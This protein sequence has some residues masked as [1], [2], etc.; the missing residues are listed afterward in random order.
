MNVLKRMRE[1]RLALLRFVCVAVIA[2][3]LAITGCAGIPVSDSKAQAPKNIVIIFADG[4]AATQWDFGRYSSKV[5]RQ[6][7]FVTADLF[8]DKAL[9]LLITSP[10]GVYVTDS[11]AA[12]SAMSTGFK[13]ENGVLSVTPDGKS[14]RTVMQA[15]KAKGKRIGLISTAPI[16]DASPAAFSMNAKSRRDSQ[17]LVDKYLALEPDVLLGGGADY[18]LPEGV[19]GG[20]R[21]DGKNIIAAF[22]S[23]GWQVMTNTAEF[24]AATGARLLGLFADE[25]MDFEIESNR[26]EQ[27]TMAEMT[28]GALRALS[29]ASP[30][31]FVLFVENENTDT[32]GHANDAASL[33][34]ALWAID[35]AVK[36]ALEFQ[37]SSPD[38]LVI[39]TGDHE[40][41]GLSPTYALKDLSSLSSSNRFYL[42]DNQMKMLAPIKMS[43]KTAAKKLGKKPSAE[44]LDALVAKHYPGF[45]LDADLRE[46]IL[47]QKPLERNHTYVVENVLGRMVARQ[48]GIYWGTGGHTSEP[49]LVGA[50]GP[51]ADLFRGYQDNTDFGRNLH[52][53]ID[54]P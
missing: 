49:V 39:V 45:K 43:F 15:A 10:H 54:G 1:P 36:V 19:S 32:V 27:P 16:Y 2:C 8:R 4:V 48:T 44:A 13:V 47:K 50:V 9:G 6:Q 22:R 3:A 23:K 33:M 7:P 40:T 51:G 18:F 5:I 42:G 28:A 14:V 17:A 12:G 41:G 21:K 31:G 46:L 30:N 38:T 29:Q 52:R 53:L 25:D 34:H 35:D 11:A 24:K 20:K 26:A 37:R